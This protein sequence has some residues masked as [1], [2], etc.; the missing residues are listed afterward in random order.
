MQNHSITATQVTWTSGSSTAPLPPLV[1]GLPVLGS[2]LEMAEDILKF[3][4][5]IYHE[6]GPICRIRVLQ[7]EYTVM[8]GPEANLFFSREGNDHFRSKEFWEGLDREMGADHSLISLDGAEHAELRQISKRGYGRS[9]LESRIPDAIAIT[10]KHLDAWPIGESR[11]VLNAVQR[12]VTEQLGTIVAG[13]A[14]GDYMDDVMNFIR[15]LLLVY[16]T[17]R[18]L[19]SLRE[20]PTTSEPKPGLSSLGMRLWKSTVTILP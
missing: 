18:G 11:P 15:T 19:A 17:R 13:T 6:Y 20:C 12:I 5:R 9:V 8:S 2:A 4:V 7:D 3:F 1:S 14:P 16:V 10:Q